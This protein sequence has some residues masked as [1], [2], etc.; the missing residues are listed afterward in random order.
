[1]IAALSPLGGVVIGIGVGTFVVAPV[2]YWFVEQ[3]SKEKRSKEEWRKS[4]DRYFE[5]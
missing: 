5:E 3:S 1:M 2:I 4:V